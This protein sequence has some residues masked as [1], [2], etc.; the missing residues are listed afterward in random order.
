MSSIVPTWLTPPTVTYLVD[1]SVPVSIFNLNSTGRPCVCVTQAVSHRRQAGLA[2]VPS[3]RLSTPPNRAVPAPPSWLVHLCA[4]VC[5]TTVC[6]LKAARAPD[7]ASCVRSFSTFDLHSPSRF[8][9]IAIVFN[10]LIDLTSH[11]TARSFHH[12]FSFRLDSAGSEHP[13]PISSP[14][15]A[16]AEEQVRERE[17]VVVDKLSI[18]QALK[19]GRKLHCK[20]GAVNDLTITCVAALLSVN[21]SRSISV[22]SV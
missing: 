4:C 2:N 5:V 22:L 15:R 11:P 21:C 12:V 8:S 13:L 10:R 3:G 17:R 1:S 18:S 19:L 16:S 6:H 14:A 7:G 20:S 9:R